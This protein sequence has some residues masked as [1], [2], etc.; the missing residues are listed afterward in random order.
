MGRIS[1]PVVVPAIVR[2]PRFSNYSAPEFLDLAQRLAMLVAGK[3][4]GGAR[5]ASLDYQRNKYQRPGT[6]G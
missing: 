5:I 4:K 1:V 3:R 6:E 2:N